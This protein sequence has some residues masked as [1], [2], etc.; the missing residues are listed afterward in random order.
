MQ[1]PK[2]QLSVSTDF[3]GPI[4]LFLRTG[5]YYIAIQ[6]IYVFYL[7]R[8]LF[9]FSH[10]QELSS[11]LVTGKRSTEQRNNGDLQLSKQS[12]RLS[13]TIIRQTVLQ[14]DFGKNAII[15]QVTS[16]VRADT[17]KVAGVNIKT[18][19]FGQSSATISDKLDLVS[20][21]KNLGKSIHN[22]GI[23]DSHTNDIIDA[24]R[25]DLVG[26]LDPH[27]NVTALAGAGHGA[28]DGEE[29]D[30]LRGEEVGS[31]DGCGFAVLE[32]HEIDV[33]RHLIAF[34]ERHGGT[35]RVEKAARARES[36]AGNG[37]E[38]GGDESHVFKERVGRASVANEET[39]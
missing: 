6:M 7:P 28:R 32:N 10:E 21:V 1:E 9:I 2:K 26:G 19:F 11:R 16:P 8:L 33:E 27:G 37:V 3:C 29:G 30:L 25:L 18:Q 24:L 22:E 5:R 31:G 17:A 15:D 36:G 39:G 12:L 23:V 34:G 13:G 35:S 38:T 4:G 14:V 20:A